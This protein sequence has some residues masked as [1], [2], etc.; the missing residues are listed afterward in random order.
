MFHK[1]NRLNM[2]VFEYLFLIGYSIIV[3]MGIFSSAQVT[4]SDWWGKTNTIMIGIALLLMI[5]GFV[6]YSSVND[7]AFILGIILIVLCV[8][9]RQESDRGKEIM[10]FTA[11]TFLG[12]LIDWKKTIRVFFIVS[13]CAIV[14]VLIL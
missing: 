11:V 9:I 1:D 3:V 2:S 4:Y 10:T 7:R 8:L 5:T 12:G 14:T 13:S 6:F